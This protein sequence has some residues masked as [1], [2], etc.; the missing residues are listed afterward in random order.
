M[1]GATDY[2][3]DLRVY[4]VVVLY[5][6]PFSSENTVELKLPALILPCQETVNVFTHSVCPYVIIYSYSIKW[7]RFIC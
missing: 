1:N 6:L 3:H 4:P 2:S 7:Y 5:I